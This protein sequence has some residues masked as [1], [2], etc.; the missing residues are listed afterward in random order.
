MILGKAIKKVFKFI[1]LLKIVFGFLIYSDLSMTRILVTD[2]E[3]LNT[4]YTTLTAQCVLLDAIVL[5]NFL[6]F[7]S[8]NQKMK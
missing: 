2:F 4:T 3:L 5:V 6:L 1:L 8:N 7:C